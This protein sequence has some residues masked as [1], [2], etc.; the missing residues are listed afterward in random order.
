MDE[1]KLPNLKKLAEDRHLLEAGDDAA[2]G[3]AR[4]LGE[5]RDRR[6]PGQAQHLRL[7]DPRLRDLPAR[8]RRR[9]ARAAGV[10]VGL[11]PDEAA[12]AHLD[13]R[14]ARRSGCTRRPT[15]SRAIVLTVPMTFPP[16]EMAHGEML[17]AA[18]RC[19]T[20]AARSARSTTGRRDLSSF[21]EG[22]VEFGGFLKRLLFEG[23][24]AR[25]DAQGAGEPDPA[26]RRSASSRRSRRRAASSEKRAGAAR[27]SS[28]PRKDINV[29]FSVRWTEGS[30]A[31]RD[32]DPGARSSRS[33]PAS[34][35]P[36]CR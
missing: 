3:V 16:E 13:A 35:A 27:A 7:P 34:G 6:E 33:R 19:P 5:L 12:E 2:V 36:G 9:E 14:R 23:G 10:P 24:V 1:G 22:N 28:R 29:P 18:C 11:L 8:L 26:G 4:R 21:E 17:S 32:R 25:D 15:A 30:G 20:C 31:R